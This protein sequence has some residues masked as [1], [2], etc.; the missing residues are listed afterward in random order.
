MQTHLQEYF[1][2]CNDQESQM[3]KKNLS[4]LN[5]NNLQHIFQKAHSPPAANP[6]L[7]NIPFASSSDPLASKWYDHGLDLISKNEVLIIENRLGLSFWQAVK[8]QD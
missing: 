4:S 5:Y 2:L 6:Q 7:S 1:K 8:A 3:L